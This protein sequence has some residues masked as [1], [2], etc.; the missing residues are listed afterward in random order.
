MKPAAWIREPVFL[1][2]LSPS[3]GRQGVELSPAGGGLRG[4]T[5]TIS[6]FIPK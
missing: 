4:W 5:S 2:E 1:Y 3:G 6:H